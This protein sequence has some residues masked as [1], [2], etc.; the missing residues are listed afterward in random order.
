MRYFPEP[1]RWPALLGLAL[2]AAPPGVRAQ[3]LYNNGAAL[4]I[5][6]GATVY[7]QGDLLNASGSTL[8]NAGTLRVTGNTTNNAAMSGGG[9]TLMLA[10]SSAQTLGGT[11]DF[12]ATDV[13]LNNAAGLTLATRLRVAG[14]MSFTNGI[15]TAASASTPL[16]FGATGTVA[17]TPTDASHVKGYVAKEG[18]GAF[19]Y[20]LGDGTRYQPTATALTANSAGL[21]ARYVP[22][23]AGAAPFTAGGTAATPL[24]AYNRF[25]YWDLTPLGTA[26]GSVTIFFDNYKNPGITSVADLRVAHQSGGAWLNEGAAASSGTATAGTVTSNAVSTWSPFALGSVAASSPLPVELL[27]FA[28]ERQGDAARLSWATATE[29]NS[30]YFEVEA[31]PDGTA[32]RAVG[33]V[34]AQGNSSQRHDYELRDPALVRY[35]APVVYYRLRQV[36][37]DGTFSYSPV[38]AL[39]VRPDGPVAFQAVAWPNPAEAGRP[40]QLLVRGPEP[41]RPLELTL[42][43]AAGRLLARRTASAAGPLALPET[44]GLP[45]GVYLLTVRQGAGQQ[46]LRLLRP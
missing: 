23:D 34:A 29:K 42:T 39:A 10:G 3:A 28:A 40:T 8:A 15:V 7:V 2:L 5:G 30:A 9:G 4:R 18:T 38:R 37:L 14:A 35:G 33:R 12:A 31:S 45:A 46:V 17:G 13:V 16:T 21:L 24:L 41:T 20:P 11:A 26:T 22:A 27:A 32:F 36:D 6:A 44:A 19:T 1:A 43:D 25:E